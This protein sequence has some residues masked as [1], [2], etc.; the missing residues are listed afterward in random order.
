MRRS[1][2]SFAGM[3]GRIRTRPYTPGTNGKVE[4]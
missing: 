2:G 3:S 1:R 4:R